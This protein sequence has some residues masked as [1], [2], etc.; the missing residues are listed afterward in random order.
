MKGVKSA[1]IFTAWFAVAILTFGP[2]WSGRNGSGTYTVP[3]T[4]TAGQTIT[5]SGFN[6][7]FSDIGTEI[8]NSVAAD[9][10]TTM[11]APLKLSNGTATSPSL[12]FG[13]DTNT[14]IYRS[15]ADQIDI[16]SGGVDTVS[17]NTSF[18]LNVAGDVYQRS[19][20]LVPAGLVLYTAAASAP[21]GYL[22]AD[23]S[24]VSRT[25]Y[26]TLFTA[27]STTY[28]SGNGSTTFNVPNCTNPAPAASLICI[29]KY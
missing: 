16:T 20:I 24:A 4:F 2:T 8:S 1:L 18:G 19:Y 11:T 6:Q 28:G 22:P 10:Q 5:A 14:G 23:G 15:G 27:I 9:G 29:I 17:V 12:T 26:A 13:S 21:T 7:N 3:N 25:T